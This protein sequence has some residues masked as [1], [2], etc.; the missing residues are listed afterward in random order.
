[1]SERNVPIVLFLLCFLI[2]AEFLSWETSSWPGPCLLQETHEVADHGGQCP[3]LIKGIGILNERLFEFAEQHDKGIVALF[4]VLLAMSTVGPGFATVLLWGAGERQ[5]GIV[6]RAVD[7]GRDQFL[8][9]HRPQIRVKHLR[10]AND[11]WQGEP[12]IV[13]LWCVNTGT[14]DAFIGEVGIAFHV[15][16]ND[17]ALPLEPRM[18]AIRNFNGGKLLT[19]RNWE[20]PDINI[21]RTLDNAENVAIQ[22]GSAKI[23]CVGWLSYLDSVDRMR[24]TGFCRVLE[25]PPSALARAD[26][27][28]FRTHLDPDY[29]YQGS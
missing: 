20:I 14:S 17:R 28:R 29:E 4:T 9:S 1:M 21:G 3:T 22:N 16:R 19:G 15:V 2:F 5:I 27:S 8:A 6:K 13:D 23:Y 11:I 24:I 26:N 10:L 18:P 7:T 12:I 25:C